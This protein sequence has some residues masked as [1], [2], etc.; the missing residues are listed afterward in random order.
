MLFVPDVSMVSTAKKV[1]QKSA[2][3]PI[4]CRANQDLAAGLKE[5]LSGFE[6]RPVPMAKGPFS[7]WDG[8]D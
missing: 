5:G 2:A 8:P 4:H 6:A 3:R 1:G 7:G